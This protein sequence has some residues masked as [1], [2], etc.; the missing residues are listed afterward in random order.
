MRFFEEDNCDKFI[1]RQQN[2]M[3]AYSKENPIKT[4][5]GGGGGGW[6]ESHGHQI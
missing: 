4:V 6:I 5:T 2:F 3:F 1:D